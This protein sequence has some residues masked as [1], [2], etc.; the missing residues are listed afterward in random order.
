MHII[1]AFHQRVGVFRHHELLIGRNNENFNRG[2]ICADAGFRIAGTRK[3]V[4]FRIDFDAQ[5][6]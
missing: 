3:L 5:V 2:I 1:R 6:S 4:L